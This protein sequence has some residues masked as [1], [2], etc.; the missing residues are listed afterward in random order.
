VIVTLKADA[1]SNRIKW[2][3]G[4]GTLILL[5][6]GVFV[7]PEPV[8]AQA[9]TYLAGQTVSPAYEGW[10]QKDDG[11]RYFVFG[12]MNRNWKE[13]PDVPIGRD[14]YFA[15]T[16]V[17]EL[18]DLTVDAYDAAEAD[19]GQPTHFL[20]RRNRFVFEVPV[21]DGW[22]EES[23]DH[24][25][26][27][28]L[29]TH[30][31]M[32]RAYASLRHDMFMDNVVIMS[33]TGALGAGHSDPE[34]RANKPPVVEVQGK[35]EREVQVGEPITLTVRVTDDGIPAR[36]TTTVMPVDDNGELDL[37]EA[38]KHPPGRV[39]VNKVNGLWFAWS[40]YRGP[41]AMT[42][43]PSQIETWEDTRAYSDSPWSLNDW[44][45]PKEPGDHLWVTKVT[46][47]KPGL[48][49]LRGRADDGGLYTN[50]DVTIRVRSPGVSQ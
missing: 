44:V 10:I 41:R 1:R 30:G 9:P 28:S 6:S 4:L 50:V 7:H 11:S 27:W 21:P 25:L 14:N 24:E 49:V 17:G 33:E 35:T 8:D 48:Y 46:F 23:E 47:H 15:V 40:P 34:L 5:C 2:L 36:D 29:R 20:P 22:Q 39:T 13:E 16:D 26:V 45:P 12:Y 32:L 18:T 31:K 43:D 3:V 38:L 37:E 42:F 19:R